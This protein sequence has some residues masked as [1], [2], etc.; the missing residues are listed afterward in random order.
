M[1][2]A[3]VVSP[4]KT[5]ALLMTHPQHMSSD[6]PHAY[7]PRDDNKLAHIHAIMMMTIQNHMT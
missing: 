6:R 7:T 5:A 4:T 2:V 1:V 3:V